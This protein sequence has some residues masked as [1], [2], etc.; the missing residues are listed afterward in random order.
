MMA[1]AHSSGTQ[2][3]ESAGKRPPKGG[4]PGADFRD[5]A[6]IARVDERLS[7][8]SVLRLCFF[9]FTVQTVRE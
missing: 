5:V 6:V 1:P 2:H 4:Y 9:W 3:S 8:I 7:V